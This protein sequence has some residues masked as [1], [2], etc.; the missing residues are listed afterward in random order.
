[1]AAKAAFLFAKEKPPKP[2]PRRF[3]SQLLLAGLF[4]L[5]D[6]VGLSSG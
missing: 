2:K 4:A 6:D 5:M 1:M 3:L